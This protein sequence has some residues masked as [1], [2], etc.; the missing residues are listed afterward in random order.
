MTM[1]KR[2]GLLEIEIGNTRSHSVEKL[3]LDEAVDLS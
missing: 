1:R 2:E 3:A